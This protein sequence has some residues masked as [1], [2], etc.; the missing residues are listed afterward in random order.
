MSLAIISSDKV[1]IALA[2]GIPAAVA[3]LIIV[4]DRP[5]KGQ[6][7]WALFSLAV[8]V[9]TGVGV[10][11]AFQGEAAQSTPAA[12]TTQSPPATTAPPV[13]SPPPT[14]GSPSNAPPACQPKGTDLHITASGIAFDTDCLAA[15]AGTA[16][17]ITFDNKDAGMLHNIHIF[18]DNPAQD[19]NAQ[20]LFVGD[21]VT[22]PATATYDVDAQPAGTYFFHCDVHPA[23]MFGTFVSG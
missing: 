19:P 4:W 8:I 16:F 23:Q 13:A 18:S 21:L 10:W 3:V 6:A 11:A 7:L 22:G 20:S 17:T 14:Q 9:G 5:R 2:L 12:I 15:P 1:V